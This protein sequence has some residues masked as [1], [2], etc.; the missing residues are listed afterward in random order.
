MVTGGYFQFYVCV[1]DPIFYDMWGTFY[2]AMTTSLTYISILNDDSLVL[3]CLTLVETWYYLTLV[4][5]IPRCC[6][7]RSFQVIAV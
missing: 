4:E 2:Y 5:T 6:Q 1:M 3:G 7:A